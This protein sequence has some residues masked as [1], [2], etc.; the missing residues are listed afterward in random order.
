M[1]TL[2]RE[3]PLDTSYLEIKVTCAGSAWTLTGSRLKTT[4][5]ETME[6]NSTELSKRTWMP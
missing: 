5:L 1:Y 2:E 6:Y 4:L 3:E